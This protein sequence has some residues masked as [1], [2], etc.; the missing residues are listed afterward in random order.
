MFDGLLISPTYLTV[1]N[2]LNVGSMQHMPSG[3][4]LRSTRHKKP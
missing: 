1:C 3:K 4:K 2:R